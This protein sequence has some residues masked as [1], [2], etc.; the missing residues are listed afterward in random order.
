MSINIDTKAMSTYF[1]GT[2]RLIIMIGLVIL[3]GFLVSAIYDLVEP[4]SP[5]QEY[6][7][8]A[9]A[10]MEL[11]GCFDLPDDQISTCQWLCRAGDRIQTCTPEK[12]PLIRLNLGSDG[13]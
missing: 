7:F 4:D 5:S 10:G 6:A 11:Y 2:Y 1:W 8:V 9:P 12:N 13:R 3:V